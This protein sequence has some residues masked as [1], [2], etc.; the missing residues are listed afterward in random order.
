MVQ[1]FYFSKKIIYY[2]FFTSTMFESEF[3][4]L[5]IFVNDFL[6]LNPNLFSLLIFQIS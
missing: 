3:F 2:T 6:T 5:Y 4:Y 1:E